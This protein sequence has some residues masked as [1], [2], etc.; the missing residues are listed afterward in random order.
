[1]PNW[2]KVITSG[3][4]AELNSLNIT[5]AL[6][7]SGN[8]YPTDAGIDRQL[9][10]TDGVGNITFGYPEEIVAIVKNVSG[11]TLLKGTPVHAT[12]SGAMGNIVGIIAASAS[13]ATSM[14][15]TFV[16]NETLADEA[17]GEALA[18]GFIQGV[19]TSGFEVGQIVYVGENGGYTNIKPTGSNLIQN[20]GIVT[21]IDASNG[22]GYILGAGRS[23]DIPNL[24]PDSVWVGNS[25]S[26]PTAVLTSSLLVTS[27]LTA[28]HAPAYVL[29]SVT[30]SMLAPY[31]LSTQTSSL[32][33][34]ASVSLNTIT[35]TKGDASTFNITV[36][37]GSGGGGAAFPYTGSAEITGSL[38]VT[39]SVE[40]YKS[41]ST[42]F[43]IQGSQGQ[44][45]S[46][47]DSLSGSLFSV[48]DISGIPILEVFSDDT[49][50]IGTF[51]NEAIIVD[52]DYAYITGSYNGDGFGLT[53]ISGSSLYDNLRT[54]RFE[55]GVSSTAEIS[56]GTKGLKTVPYLGTIIGW[57]LVSDTP[58]STVVDLWK[59]N[60]TIPLG[61]DSITGT[62]KPTLT[63]SQLATSTTLTGWT[64]SVSPDD[65]FLLYVDS[66]NLATY[67]SLE[68]DILLT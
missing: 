13:L 68:L 20:L 40:I 51:N 46:V 42:V 55:M 54:Y 3:S 64:T 47:T 4:N 2:K 15:A 53:N 27:A 49:V 12:A 29:T 5:T 43:D 36:D 26:V 39:G 34:T 44:L 7:A 9:L 28:S 56:T 14:P 38:V 8:I 60:G 11:T 6:T 10:K 22:S 35:F 62:A 45:F 50:K 65:V 66:N 37:T 24:T 61:S 63:T 58:T 23:N 59:R 33:T 18:A 57:K 52:G 25:D 17:E 19:N 41:G 67:I 30:S 32:I 21:K 31:L 48:N 16:L 1:M